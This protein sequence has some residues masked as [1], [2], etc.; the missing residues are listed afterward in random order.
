MSCRSAL[1]WCF[2]LAVCRPSPAL[3]L[4]RQALAAIF[5]DEFIC[6]GMPDADGD[7]EWAGG[8]A[9]FSMRLNCEELAEV[10]TAPLYLL[11]G[12]P[13]SYPQVAPKFALAPKAGGALPARHTGG[14]A[15]KSRQNVQLVCAAVAEAIEA[16]A[17]AV[18]VYDMVTAARECLG[19]VLG[20]GDAVII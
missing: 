6:P 2:V 1:L 12:L 8:P 15:I 9:V 20:A 16:N 11:V 3:T 17:G 19:E 14:N 10:L 5:M 7:A 18:C 4:A 13:P